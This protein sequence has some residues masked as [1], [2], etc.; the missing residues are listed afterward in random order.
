MAAREKSREDKL[1]NSAFPKENLFNILP[2][3]G[4]K[5]RGIG[6]SR[7]VFFHALVYIHECHMDKCRVIDTAMFDS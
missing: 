2:Y 5:V 3:F 7:L 6:N 1:K 4:R